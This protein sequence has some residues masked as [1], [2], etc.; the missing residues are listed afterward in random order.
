M[1]FEASTISE[2]RKITET[3]NWDDPEGQELFELLEFA[4]YGLPPENASHGAGIVAPLLSYA[5]TSVIPASNIRISPDRNRDP[6]APLRPDDFQQFITQHPTGFS[7]GRQDIQDLL[8]AAE[9]LEDEPV[10]EIEITDEDIEAAGILS[11]M[12]NISSSDIDLDVSSYSSRNDSDYESNSDYESDSDNDDNSNYNTESEGDYGGGGKKTR[13]NNRKKYKGSK[14][15]RIQP[16]C[17]GTMIG[18]DELKLIGE[19]ITKKAR[20]YAVEIGRRFFTKKYEE[21]LKDLTVMN[22]AL[23]AM[24]ISESWDIRWALNI[25]IPDVIL[26]DPANNQGSY[27]GNSLRVTTLPTLAALGVKDQDDLSLD[28]PTGIHT[29]AL[30]VANKILQMEG[31]CAF[32]FLRT[33]YLRSTVPLE[34]A[35]VGLYIWAFTVK[36]INVGNEGG[37]SKTDR[38]ILKELGDPIHRKNFQQHAPIPNMRN[39]QHE[40]ALLVTKISQLCMHRAMKGLV[41]LQTRVTKISVLA[42]LATAGGIITKRVGTE[43][44][45]ILFYYPKT[46]GL[47]SG[48]AGY[49][50]TGQDIL[51]K[52]RLRNC[53]NKVHDFFFQKRR[54]MLMPE[55]L[56]RAEQ[57]KSD[58][59]MECENKISKKFYNEPFLA[60]SNPDQMFEII[61]QTF[62]E[63]IKKR[64][65][66][67][68]YK[69]ITGNKLLLADIF[70]QLILH[71]Y[72]DSDDTERGQVMAKA[73]GTQNPRAEAQKA[74]MRCAQLA[75]TVTILQGAPPPENHVSWVEYFHNTL[76]ASTTVGS[77]IDPNQG[78]AHAAARDATG[79]AAAAGTQAAQRGATP[80]QTARVMAQ[81]AVNSTGATS[82][83]QANHAAT[84]AF[85]EAGQ[86]FSQ[87][88]NDQINAMA[89]AV[90]T[91]AATETG[92][93]VSAEQAASLR[94][95]TGEGSV[96]QNT[97][98]IVN[99]VTDLARL[100]DNELDDAIDENWRLRNGG[101]QRLVDTLF[102]DKNADGQK[103]LINRYITNPTMPV[104]NK[105]QRKG[106]IVSIINA[107]RD[108]IMEGLQLSPRG[109][110]G[111]QSPSEASNVIQNNGVPGPAPP[112]PDLP[113]VPPE[114]EQYTGPGYSGTASGTSKKSV[115]CPPCPPCPKRRRKQSKKSKKSK[116]AK[117][118]K[119]AKKNRTKR[120]LEG[121]KKRKNEEQSGG[122]RINYKSPRKCYTYC[123][124]NKT[125]KKCNPK[126]SPK[127]YCYK[128]VSKDG[129]EYCY[130]KKGGPKGK[131]STRKGKLRYQYNRV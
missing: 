96:S 98:N 12:R 34:E 32:A 48:I 105:N 120:K 75:S 79:A 43:I 21:S 39:L 1:S 52:T 100:S 110:S 59:I 99:L 58:M 72:P 17:G 88:P 45:K 70:I 101:A 61:K 13:T 115:S 14:K 60:F 80:E 2:Y 83:Q 46:I 51:L 6:R 63:V 126:K 113:Y 16:Q 25:F 9:Q 33:M 108:A 4:L 122:S 78:R 121:K 81:T 40:D 66:L 118:A 56:A 116:K 73:G 41:N 19:A 97:V 77:D 29:T 24:N 107:N 23:R 130:W 125:K 129:Y 112:A 65:S 36:C 87:N 44:L 8:M 28:E 30:I 82:Q 90:A 91:T 64:G 49:I 11:R 54:S 3:D 95:I 94:G 114:G 35:L 106:A 67:G 131:C 123:S 74:R 76:I 111:M 103:E 62:E 92:A 124:H 84:R 57:I 31:R 86:A 42:P 50:K 37:S 85:Q 71:V 18:L 5:N 27:S 10:E 20:P 102:L 104:G 68:E 7:A 55:A 89:V 15:K 69:V 128:R 53:R 127:G 117:K 109:E 47:V 93:N 119:K 38:N 26:V 22:N